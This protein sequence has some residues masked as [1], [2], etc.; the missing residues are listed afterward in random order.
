MLK[1]PTRLH[2]VTLCIRDFHITCSKT[3]RYNKN[4]YVYI[5]NVTTKDCLYVDMKEFYNWK[6]AV[7]YLEVNN[8]VES[9]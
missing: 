6:I 4:R 1:A 5:I 2:I 9:K 7:K 8:Y 3:Y